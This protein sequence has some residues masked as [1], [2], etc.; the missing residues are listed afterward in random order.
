MTR[1]RPRTLGELKAA[2]YRARPV[3]D[4]IRAN[5][6][7][8]LKAGGVDRAVRGEEGASDHAPVWIELSL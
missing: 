2:G 4:E 5:L 3:K 6:V 8:K 7:R 1:L